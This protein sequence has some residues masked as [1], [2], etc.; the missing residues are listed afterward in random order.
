[1]ELVDK[2]N[3]VLL[4]KFGLPTSWS[5]ISSLKFPGQDNS[6][7]HGAAPLYAEP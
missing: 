5:L 4:S 6:Y 3:V 7:S 2:K 1:M